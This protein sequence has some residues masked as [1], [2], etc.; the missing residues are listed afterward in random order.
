MTDTIWDT[1]ITGG[2]VFDGHGKLP[3]LIDIA[4][5]DGRV[6]A[7]GQGLPSHMAEEVVDASGQWVMP[8]LLDIHTHLDLEVDLEPGLPEVVRHGTTTVLVGNCSLGT[9]FGSQVT[10]D[11]NPIVDC[12][13]RVEN[14]PKP[15]LNKC[16]EAV[17]WD[18]T[19]D[20]MD[21]FGDLNLGPNIAAL[22]PHSMLRVEVMGLQDSI[23]RAPTDAEVRQMQELLSNALD[24]GYVGM[25]TDGLPFHYLSNDPNT[26]KRIPTQF[27]T[28]RELKQLL[29]VVRDRDRVWQTTPIIENRLEAFLYFAFTSGRLFGK[30]LKTSALAVMEFALM[31]KSSG[32]FL[33]FAR[34]MNSKFFDGNMHF[35][36]LG[37]NFRVW[38]DGIVSP[39]YEELESCCRLIAR[40]YDD[41]EGRLAL[42]N[43]PQFIEDFRR[44]WHHGR[45]GWNLA[46]LKARMGAPDSLVVRELDMMHFDGA[47]VE[48]WNGDTLQQVFERV[49]DFQHGNSGAARSES[50][51]EVL[52]AFPVPLTDDADFMLHMMREYDKS[53][54]FWVDVGNVGNRATLE[55]LLHEQTM[56]GFND[57]G[58]HITN[59]A[60]FDANLSSLRLAQADSMATVSRMIERLT[61]EPAEFFGLDVG[62]LDIGARAD[63]TMIDPDQLREHDCD[64]ER[65]LIYRD[66]FEHQQM[67]NRSDGVV[68]RVMIKGE[69]VWKDQDFTAALGTRPL[70][71]A[72]RA[73]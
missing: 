48:A 58:A 11:Q 72:L 63:V 40:E 43:D 67:V 62:T 34:L 7:K 47:P 51:R 53:F 5:S 29:Q 64:R 15:V 22:V 56:P 41:R 36:A 54:R 23:S 12:F 59:M 13:T 66:L 55:L 21:H 35:Q 50:E 26:D 49:L 19:G 20:Y 3:E 61:H 6:V 14:I 32:L 31:P 4:L 46:T 27:A 18:N 57:S 52:S 69:T 42:L 39:L 10:E 45:G 65:E 37:T 38:S 30:A 44:D 24:Q 71:E 70:G 2:M 8:G 25:S 68:S 60:F 16:V 17:Q 73:G 1:L 9:C 33:G 28:R